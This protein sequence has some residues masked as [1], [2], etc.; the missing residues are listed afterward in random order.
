VLE[1]HQLEAGYGDTTVLREVSLVVP[2]G[3][4]VGL[5]GANGAGKTTLLRALSGLLSPSGGQVLLDD[6]DVTGWAPYRLVGHGVCHIPEG[7]GVF[8]QL[9]V[10]E[11]LVLQSH[12]GGEGSA[13]DAATEAFPSLSGRLGQRAGSLSGGEQQMLALAR[14]Y[15]TEPRLILLDEVSMGL[16]P[17][18]VDEIF[19]FLARL[20]ETGAALLLVEQY[21]AR[22]LGVA[23]YV[24][25]MNRGRVTF[26]GEPSELEDESVFRHYVAS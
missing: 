24:Y 2:D 7:R 5:L 11:N 15:V 13:I 6:T 9:S 4:V 8:P 10:R 21:V 19:D 12:P 20:A 18:I 23:D 1:V 3:C 16:A 25:L 14:A 22:A 26:S 17:R